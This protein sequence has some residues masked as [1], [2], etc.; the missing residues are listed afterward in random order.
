[1]AVQRYVQQQPHSDN[2]SYQTICFFSRSI[3]TSYQASE[4]RDRGF[5]IRSRSQ[6]GQGAIS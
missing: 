2:S 1:M 5:Y 4:A 3:Y 6:G